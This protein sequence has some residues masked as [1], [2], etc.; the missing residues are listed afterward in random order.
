MA[1]HSKAYI[2]GFS[3][4]VCLIC[5]VVVSFSAVMLKD[6]QEVNKTLKRQKMVLSV[7]G[8]LAEGAD[9]DAAQVNALFASNIKAKVIDLETGAYSKT[10]PAS[11]DQRKARDDLKLG[12]AAPENLAKVQR[13]PREALVY[14]VMKGEEISMLVLPIEGKGLWST[15][16]GYLALDRDTTT[17][18]GITFYEHGETPGLGGEVDNPRWKALWVDR[19]AFDPQW[20]VKLQVVK[21]QAPPADKAPYAVDGLSGATL[22]SRGVSYTV[23]FWLGADGFGPY[24]KRFR[25]GELE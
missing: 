1:Q 3:T 22:T 12:R 9:A 10:D 6:R 4:V 25:Q 17:V 7:A 14:Q 16:Y 13:I 23:G 15:M 21:G 20:N 24:L 11:F 5:A 8:V 18:R 19:K 2:I